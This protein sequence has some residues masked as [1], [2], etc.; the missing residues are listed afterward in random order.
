MYTCTVYCVRY[1]EYCLLYT[2]YYILYTVFCIL[3]TVYCI[4]YTLYCILH[5]LYCLLYSVLTQSP[6]GGLTWKWPES[7]MS[8][9]QESNIWSATSQLAKTK[10][11][12]FRGLITHWESLGKYLTYYFIDWDGVGVGQKLKISYK[13]YCLV[14]IFNICKKKSWHRHGV[15]HGRMDIVQVKLYLTVSCKFPSASINKR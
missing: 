5:T 6:D 12:R 1:T 11:S 4:L 2:L 15:C 13:H 10:Q 3:Y 8:T 7:V 9:L 14:W